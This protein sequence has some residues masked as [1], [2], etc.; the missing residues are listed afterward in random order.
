MAIT[1]KILSTNLRIA[2]TSVGV[3]FI[4]VGEVEGAGTCDQIRAVVTAAGEDFSSLR[5]EDRAKDRAS[6]S[7]KL[8]EYTRC[9]LETDDGAMV[10]YA[11]ETEDYETKEAASVARAARVNALLFCL[12]SAWKSVS[13]TGDSPTV[14]ELSN[15]NSGDTILIN[16]FPTIVES[17][18]TSSLVQRFYL[19]SSFYRMPARKITNLGTESANRHE[20]ENRWNAISKFREDDPEKI[21][22]LQNA[23]RDFEAVPH[24]RKYALEFIRY[25]IRLEKVQINGIVVPGP[26][27]GS[28]ELAARKGYLD[29]DL[30][31]NLSLLVPEDGN[32]V[33]D[34]AAVDEALDLFQWRRD[35]LA[36]D[37]LA[38]SATRA[39]L[40]VS[41]R[42]QAQVAE[43]A[44]VKW[45]RAGT[46][47][48]RV[49][50]TGS[51]E[52]DE[53]VN[54]LERARSDFLA[55]TNVLISSSAKY[56]KLTGR[57]SL[58]TA[59]IRSV[60]RPGEAVVA[61]AKGE[62]SGLW[63]IV[64]TAKNAA[65]VDLAR[66]VD[67]SANPDTNEKLEQAF[68]NFQ[69]SFSAK[70]TP[71]D[72]EA[73]HEIYRL[74]IEPFEQSFGD[75]SKLIIIPDMSFPSLSYPALVESVPPPGAAP[76]SIPWLA[77]H[78][79]ITIA[80]TVES[81]VSIRAQPVATYPRSNF[82]G[83]AN[84]IIENIEDCS[85][86][87]AY[88]LKW[89]PASVEAE[90]CPVPFTIDHLVSLARGLDA[91]PASSVITG[92]SL[93]QDNVVRMLAGHFK[94]AAFATHGL[95]TEDMER[96]GGISEPALLLSDIDSKM[97]PTSDRWLTTSEIELMTIDADLMVLSACHTSADG[98]RSGEA[99]S[100]LAR[101]FFEAGVRGIM[102]TNWYIEA[103]D[104]AEFFRAMQPFL[105]QAE[106]SGTAEILQRTMLIRMNA[107]PSPK[108]W[109][110]FTFVGG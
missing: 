63:G 109:A 59:D 5:G 4:L 38:R 9:Y 20:F 15:R 45:R 47:L 6:V 61:F 2:V 99:F 52:I 72:F 35:A 46:S 110:V 29:D 22:Q 70:E 34:E 49:R 89:R 30:L 50:A 79:A 42:Y 69:N 12:D 103:A 18:E 105:S 88:G 11:C 48:L 106:L 82:I 81:L 102:V 39:G 25:A 60:L 75:N 73:A 71:F 54:D 41:L 84:P 44:I 77:R 78:R 27:T 8:P 37:A 19:K 62:I 10:K 76:E 32:S 57:A 91:D 100:G 3:L 7:L 28:D 33:R 14:T 85:P 98:E 53:L 43:S 87:S 90:L 51:G 107:K 13:D 24:N 92:E 93:T 66:N 97:D 94:V 95:M 17:S 80:L 56:R 68:A 26:M 74:L 16:T 21:I 108:S 83:F 1:L 65:L 96:L 67:G 86:A 64:I 23:A 36:G 104:T 31:F 101:A 58:T 40:P 55:A